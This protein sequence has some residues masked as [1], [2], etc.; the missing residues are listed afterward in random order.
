MKNLSFL[1]A[2][3]VF[4][5][6][7]SILFPLLFLVPALAPETSM[8]LSPTPYTCDL[9]F[10]AKGTDIQILIGYSK[11]VGRGKISCVNTRARDLP[12]VEI[13]VKVTIGTPVLFPRV[14]FA[15]SLVVRGLATGIGILKGGP[16]VLLGKYLTVDARISVH[17]GVGAS[18][19]LEGQD[20]AIF[21]S[22]GLQGVEG[23]GIAV[24]GTV[25]ELEK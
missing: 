17:A 4:I 20:N 6:V 18:L 9:E 2:R 24:G 1:S 25:V 3:L 23:F 15:P 16:E 21:I 14:S 10:T 7:L 11:L 12:P 13:P 5:P 19:S 22:L 8:A